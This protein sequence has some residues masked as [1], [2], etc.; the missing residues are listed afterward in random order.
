M[1]PRPVTMRFLHPSNK[2][3]LLRVALE[4]SVFLGAL[5]PVDLRVVCVCTSHGVKTSLSPPFYVAAAGQ[6]G[7]DTGISSWENN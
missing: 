5:P 3:T 6:A 1:P 4:V 2:G 7:D